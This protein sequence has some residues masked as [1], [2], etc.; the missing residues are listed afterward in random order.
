M[1]GRRAWCLDARRGKILARSRVARRRRAAK[2]EGKGDVERVWNTAESFPPPCT[3]GVGE[4]CAGNLGWRRGVVA[5]PP[6]RDRLSLRVWPSLSGNLYLTTPPLPGSPRE[7]LRMEKGISTIG[8]ALFAIPRRVKFVFPPTVR[9]FPGEKKGKDRKR[10][11]I[12]FSNEPSKSFDCH[13]MMIRDRVC[14][15]TENW[16]RTIGR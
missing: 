13:S 16:I 7:E 4:K 10:W 15:S 9:V 8:P 12:K 11:R 14:L 1:V 2:V 3:R 6:S 5:P